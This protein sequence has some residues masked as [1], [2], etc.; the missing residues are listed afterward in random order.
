[1]AIALPVCPPSAQRSALAALAVR[2][3][4]SAACGARRR[5]GHLAQARGLAGEAR[6]AEALSAAGWQIHARR[7]R[8]PAGEVDIVAERE[9][10]L[11]LI[12]VKAR[13]DMAAAA[14]A[15][16]PRQQRR[17]LA[18]GA[19]LQAEN[20]HWGPE[21]LRFDAW[22]VDAAGGLHHLPDAFRDMG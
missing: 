15:I 19:I 11:T 4:R 14:A 21:G 12:E 16:G 7:L 22:L 1:M 13:D 6:V 18:A 17:L 5:R 3:P 10:I 2:A 9:G 20:P 8:T